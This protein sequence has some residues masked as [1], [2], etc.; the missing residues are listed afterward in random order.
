MREGEARG[1]DELPQQLHPILTAQYLFSK[2]NGPLTHIISSGTC[3]LGFFWN[4]MGR[5]GEGGQGWVEVAH[6]RN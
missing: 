5:G 1:T 3:L 4:G 2:L 6:L